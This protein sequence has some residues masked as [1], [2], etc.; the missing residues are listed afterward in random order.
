MVC[1]AVLNAAIV[2]VATFGVW[3][4]SVL[5]GDPPYDQA[6]A[7]AH[8]N[9]KV[10]TASVAPPK[11]ADERIADYT[12]WLA[13]FTAMLG[14]VSIVQI[15]FLIRA[16]YTARKAADAASLTAKNLLRTNRPLCIMENIILA[17]FSGMVPKIQL[18]PGYRLMSIY[19]T[20]KN[21]GNGVAFAR[22]SQFSSRI[23]PEIGDVIT[24]ENKADIFFGYGELSP[25]ESY[26]PDWPMYPV[27]ISDEDLSKEGWKLYVKGWVRYADVHGAIRRS[28]FAFEW[29]PGFIEIAADRFMPCGPSAHWYD[30]EESKI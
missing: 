12:W 22:E 23:S 28:G 11:S 30:V 25:G 26:T 8:E 7:Q 19:G 27:P 5:S 1:A 10:S 4:G 29:V 2:F 20:I 15:S 17:P 6:N 21:K 13:A 18:P 24:P 16:D 14:V 9:A 3:S